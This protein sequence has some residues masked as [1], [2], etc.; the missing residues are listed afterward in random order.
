MAKL[1]WEKPSSQLA[2]EL[3]I[4]DTAI[5]KFCKRHNLS[6]PPLGYWQKLSLSK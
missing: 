5:V 1:L 2:K 4:T 3:N 6:K